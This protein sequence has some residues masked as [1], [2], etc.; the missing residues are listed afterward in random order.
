MKSSQSAASVDHREL[1]LYRDRTSFLLRRYFVTAME[2]G[3]LPSL[4]GRACFRSRV[5]SYRTSTFEDGVIFV[6]DV[7][8]C[9]ERLDDFSKSLIATIAL[10]GYEYEEAAALLHCSLRTVE[11]LFPEALDRLASIFLECGLLNA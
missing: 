10:Q 8:R 3:R 7:E 11:R 4:L 6:H 5:S 9:L 1:R 2:T